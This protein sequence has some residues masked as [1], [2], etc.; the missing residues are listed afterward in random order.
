MSRRIWGID[1]LRAAQVSG[2]Q[3]SQWLAIDQSRI[4]AFASI[5]HDEQWIHVDPARA[6]ETSLGGTVAHGYMTLGLVT[7]M[8]EECFHVSGFTTSLNYGLN[9]VRF[10]A[11]VPSGSAIRG[12]LTISSVSEID[13]GADVQTDVLIECNVQDK[14]ACVA[15][16]LIRFIV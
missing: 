9:R 4:S 12:R 14:P 3:V 2:E 5:T 15:Q 16:T 6:R 13:G 10:P 7:A 11:P 8:W 1:G